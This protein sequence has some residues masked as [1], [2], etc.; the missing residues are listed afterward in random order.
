MLEYPYPFGDNVPQAGVT[1][2]GL[3]CE[4]NCHKMP[5]V[6]HVM[7]CCQLPIKELRV[8]PTNIP[9][10][11]PFLC[12]SESRP[13]GTWLGFPTKEK[14]E[15]HKVMM[16]SKI[17]TYDMEGGGGWDRATWPSRP[18]P[19]VVLPNPEFKA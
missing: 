4:C 2:L 11:Y 10:V 13:I 5:G 18:Q 3:P 16:D 7:A 1:S 15:A 12:G 14:A 17:D 19:W 8:T 6:L 9:V